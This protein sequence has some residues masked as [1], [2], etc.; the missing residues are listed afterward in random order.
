MNMQSTL[1][2]LAQ[3]PTAVRLSLS[4]YC[5]GL[6]E[7]DGAGFPGTEATVGISCCFK[8]IRAKIREISCGT[9]H[10]NSELLLLPL[11]QVYHPF[12]QCNVNNMSVW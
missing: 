12:I 6:T 4:K 11:W 1:Y 3:C 8:G 5:T 10:R 9:V 2:A 7:N